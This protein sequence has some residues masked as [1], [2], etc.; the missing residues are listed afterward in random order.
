MTFINKINTLLN[1]SRPNISELSG[2]IVQADHAVK[3]VS[4]AD[5]FT[6]LIQHDESQPDQ[7]LI[8][9]GHLIA[10]RMDG[11]GRKGAQHAYHNHHH[12]KKVMLHAYVLCKLAKM[13]PTKAVL[14]AM[15]HD[16]QHDGG[17]NYVGDI[18]V[19][20]RL[21]N[22]AIEAARPDMIAA[23]VDQATQDYIFDM[24][25]WTDLGSRKDIKN[26]SEHA[27]ILGDSDLLSAIGLTGPQAWKDDSDYW[28]EHGAPIIAKNF[29]S[30]A[31]NVAGGTFQS[32]SGKLFNG[33]IM[34][35][36][37][38]MERAVIKPMNR[39]AALWPYSHP[40]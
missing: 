19:P 14:A 12:G 21:E 1:N 18:F 15:F 36:I 37:E 20:Y 7:S 24:V 34:P 33:N 9:A 16:D 4:F 25:R 39:K 32:K 11:Q 3:D 27:K 2:A 28:R 38:Y 31:L 13:G 23:G 8:R 29:R 26:P 10:T 35:I 5:L 6:T 22:K 30:F 40:S 17:T